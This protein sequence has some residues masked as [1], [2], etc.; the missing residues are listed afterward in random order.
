MYKLLFS[1]LVLFISFGNVYAQ[2]EKPTWTL[3]NK[4]GKVLIP[5]SEYLQIGKFSN[6]LC[7]VQNI[8]KK[9]GYINNQGQ[10]VLAF[11]YDFAQGFSQGIAIVGIRNK[12]G[13]AIFGIVDY[14]GKEVLPIKYT[15]VFEIHKGLYV[16][17]DKKLGLVDRIGTII[18]KATFDEILPHSYGNGLIPV[19]KDGKW[20]YLSEEG[21]I[22][23]MPQFHRA[24]PFINGRALI[25]KNKDAQELTLIDLTGNPIFT[26]PYA[27]GKFKYK[28][29]RLRKDNLI[30]FSVCDTFN[31]VGE[32]QKV[33]I[34][35]KDLKGNKL[36]EAEFSE[37]PLFKN[38]QAIAI[39]DSFKGILNKDGSSLTTYD[40][41]QIFPFKNGKAL[42]KKDKNLLVSINQEGKELEVIGTFLVGNAGEEFIPAASCE[43]CLSEEEITKW[44][45]LNLQGQ[46]VIDEQFTAAQTFINNLAPVKNLKGLWGFIDSEGSIVIPYQFTK[47]QHFDNNVAWVIKPKPT[48]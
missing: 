14:K 16:F 25:L 37:I 23:I 1:F 2:D 12:Q 3:I 43:K 38:N 6:G 10:T 33:S 34:G 19:K 46:F 36:C 9:W 17:G 26:L 4:S 42:A 40:Y 5:S 32:C 30:E 20:G 48:K 41:Y 22:S 21:E 39:K 31:E 8:R 45:F 35:L 29:A 15:K 18:L 7:A 13:K 28:D 11:K 47:I 24:D 27:T 44:G